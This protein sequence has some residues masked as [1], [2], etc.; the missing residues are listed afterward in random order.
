MQSLIDGDL[1]VYRAGFACQSK[2][3]QGEVVAEPL[4]YCLHTVKSMME[5][6]L[7]KVGSHDYKVFLTG[8]DNFRNKIDPEYKAN[9][10]DAPKP[11]HYQDI[12]KYLENTWDA[13]VIDGMEADD[14]LGMCS[15]SRSVICSIDKDLLMVEGNHYN[16]VKDEWKIITP[17]EGKLNFYR[18]M[19]TG[20]STDNIPGI[21]GLGPKK[22]TDIL[23]QEDDWDSVIYELYKGQFDRPLTRMKQNALLLWIKQPNKSI[24]INFRR[25]NV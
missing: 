14:A 10:K 7:E 1:L 11:V 24:P 6:I 2:D 16:F 19:I 18:Q 3:E 21:K 22:S 5:N 4:P 20:D 23:T 8:K 9:R 17:L 12:R 13:Y 25:F 15:H